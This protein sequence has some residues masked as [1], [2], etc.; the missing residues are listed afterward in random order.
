VILSGLWILIVAANAYY[1]VP[2]SVLPVIMA[3]LAVDPAGASLLISVMFGAQMLLGVPVGVLLDRVDNRLAIGIATSFL[4][5]IYSL[6]WQSAATDA[7][8]LLLASRVMAAPATAAVWTA[9]ITIIGRIFNQQ[10]ATAVGVFSGGPAA[11]FA[12]GLLSG[13]LITDRFGWLAIFIIYTIPAVIGCGVFWITSRGI[14]IS[15]SG[16]GPPQAANFRELLRDRLIW[17]VAFMAFLGYSIYAFITSWVPTYLAGEFGISLAQGGLFVALFPAI[18]IFARGGS[19]AISD[20]FFDHRRRPVAIISFIIS[21]PAI[22]LIAVVESEIWMLLALVFA[23]FFVQLGIGLFYAQA[24]EIVDSSVAA[25]GVA[26]TTSM[27]M[28]GGFSAPLV[29]GFLIEFSGYS[30]AFGYA[31]VVALTGLAFAWITPEPDL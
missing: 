18:G 1:M 21:A 13:P 28:F 7:Y 30:A 27:A 5:V 14:D 29:G 8:W 10:Q 4:V 15:G 16:I 22:L 20:Y 6:S 24:R 11:G 3:R 25:T 9:G 12:L 26:F 19:G 31:V 2:A 23:G 17:V